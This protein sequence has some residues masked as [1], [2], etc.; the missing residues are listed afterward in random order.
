MSSYE[1]IIAVVFALGLLFAG[2]FE[3]NAQ[4]TSAQRYEVALAGFTK[5]S[6]N[7][8]DEAITSPAVSVLL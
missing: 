3:A 7:D 5:D 1:R 2:V 6:F 4:D 8:T